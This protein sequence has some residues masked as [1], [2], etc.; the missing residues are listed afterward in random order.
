MH[1][2]KPPAKVPREKLLGRRKAPKYSLNDLSQ[3]ARAHHD[4]GLNGNGPASYA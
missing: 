4:A 3:A 2:V 1:K